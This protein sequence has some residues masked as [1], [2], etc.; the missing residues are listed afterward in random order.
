MSKSKRKQKRPLFPISELPPRYSDEYFHNQAALFRKRVTLYCLTA[1]A[2]FFVTSIQY[3]VRNYFLGMETFRIRELW[4]WAIVFAANWLCLGANFRSRSLSASRKI[5][6]LFAT[7]FALA[8]SMLG[9]IYSENAAVFVFY[10]AFTLLL[11]SFIIPWC[12]TDLIY[13]AGIYIAAYAAFYSYVIFVLKV[14]VVWFPRFHPLIDG[15]ILILISFIIAFIVKRKD[16]ERDIENFVLLKQVDEKNQQTE[17]ELELAMRVH[18]TLIPESI[19]VDKARIDVTYFPVGKVGGDYA[20]FRFVDEDKLV[21]FMSD[22]TGHGVPAALLVNRLHAEFE[23]LAR[24]GKTPGIL[25][26]E[27]N[28]FICRDFEGTYMYLSAFC[29]V[30]DFSKMKFMYSNYGHPT[31]YLYRYRAPEIQNLKSQAGL[32]GVGAADEKDVYQNEIPFEKGDHILLFTD[33]VTEA[34]NPNG[35]FYGEERV[36]EFIKKSTRNKNF[37]D[38]LMKELRS[39]TKSHFNDDIFILNIQTSA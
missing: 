35:E 13:L 4:C 11:T 9:V 33:G 37:N 18:R 26:H 10:F 15:V 16:I 22:V 27:L 38:L 28:Q 25:M 32:L 2:I 14:P 20:K 24:E 29:G 39:F 31:Q 12:L 3:I 5:A 21:F 34:I 8:L 36:V 7:S 17:Q 6:Y 19:E 23:R 1:T 30:L